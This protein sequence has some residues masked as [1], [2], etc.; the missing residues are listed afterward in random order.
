MKA[1]IIGGSGH[2]AFALQAA[3]LR[4]D[5]TLCAAAPGSAKEDISGVMTAAAAQGLPLRYYDDYRT[6]LDRESAD[7][8]VVNPWFCDTA[9][10]S[11]AC[12]GRGLHVF[13]EKPLATTLGKLDELTEAWRSSGRALDGMFNLRCCGWF[14]TVRKAVD[15][16]LIGEV[17]QLQG[18]KSYRMGQRGE[19]YRKRET[20]GGIIPW[21]G[22][23]ALDWVLQLGGKCEWVIGT[24]DA[25]ENRGHGEMDVTSAVMLK[26]ENGVIGT[27]TADFFRP[28]GSLRHDDD[29]LRVTGTKGTLYA[30]DG[31]VF[32]EDGQNRRELPLIGERNCLLDMLD[33]LGTPA[34]ERRALDALEVTRVALMA[35]DSE[36]EGKVLYL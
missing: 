35:R 30:Y 21:V 9:E 2:Y 14:N 27:V 11:T 8:A 34:S 6:M 10:V 33:A 18:R 25:H 28:D 7:L 17:R 4:G 12:L 13:S 19:V 24:Q 5:L 20:F 36:A 23:H 29:R 16:G 15:D 22:I 32:I 31:R 26:M 3:A 1:V